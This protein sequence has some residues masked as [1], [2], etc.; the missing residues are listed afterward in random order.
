MKPTVGVVTD[1][2]SLSPDLSYHLTTAAWQRQM[3]QHGY[4]AT[5]Y[6]RTC[7]RGSPEDEK[8]LN[9]SR[10]IPGAPKILYENTTKERDPKHDSSVKILQPA[11]EDVLRK[12]DVVIAHDF[13]LLN[14]YVVLHE[15]LRNAVAKVSGEGR[16]PQV[17]HVYHSL[18]P[19]T[20]RLRPGDA[21]QHPG[22]L[23]YS[24][25]EWSRPVSLSKTAAEG[26]AQ[27]LNLPV[28]VVGILPN[29]YVQPSEEVVSNLGHK[30]LQREVIQVLP[31]CATR[32]TAKGAKETIKL[33]AALKRLKTQVFLILATCNSRGKKGQDGVSD[34]KAFAERQGL[35]HGEDYVLTALTGKAWEREVP[36]KVLLELQSYADLFAFFSRWEMCSNALG[37]AMRCGQIV[38]LTGD[39]PLGKEICGS[40]PIYVRHPLPEEKEEYWNE[41][42]ARVL[43][44]VRSEMAIRTRRIVRKRF[45]S[46][47]LFEEYMEP[48]LNTRIPRSYTEN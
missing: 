27:N 15:A 17:L 6:V 10:T 8:A 30:W 29:A 33:F 36:H 21:Y 23:K 31:F 44:A 48:L 4:D 34:M 11:F 26:V 20:Q 35:V 14:N 22:R 16:E 18:F 37:E 32:Y 45:N 41:L 47:R 13:M 39:L 1:F 3:L 24:P 42:A 43:R 40:V 28:D 38:V 9:L 2:T 5:L 12:H 19:F 46:A 7:F 25:M